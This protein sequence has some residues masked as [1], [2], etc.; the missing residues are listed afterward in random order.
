MT[1]RPRWNITCNGG[2]RPHDPTP[3]GFIVDASR[4]PWPTTVA[5]QQAHQGL[6]A[7]VLGDRYVP[8]EIEAPLH[9]LVAFSSWEE[10]EPAQRK[11]RK[12]ERTASGISLDAER[13]TFQ[14]PTCGR[15]EVMRQTTLRER[16][17]TPGNNEHVALDS[18][19][20]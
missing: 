18:I 16:L 12:K 1:R 15:R 3:L 13:I 10:L 8:G 7:R 14:C 20:V 9:G 5:A 6:S 19:C 2:A 17:D 11:R 4:T